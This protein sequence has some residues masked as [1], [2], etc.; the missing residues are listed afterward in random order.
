MTQAFEGAS[1]AP[2]TNTNK[3]Q[4]VYRRTQFVVPKIAVVAHAAAKNVRARGT[5]G[6]AGF[7]DVFSDLR[8]LAASVA[9]FLCLASLQT[10]SFAE[11]SQL[12]FDPSLCAED[13][14]DFVYVALWQSVFRIPADQLFYILDHPPN[15]LP[16]VPPPPKPDDPEGCPGHP[17]QAAVFDLALRLDAWPTNV[18][19]PPLVEGGAWRFKLVASGPEQWGLQP[20][21]ENRHHSACLLA[22][23]IEQDA[24]G[25][26]ICR[27]PRRDKP[28]DRSV[29]AFSAYADPDIYAAPLDRLFTSSCLASIND[30]YHNCRVAYKVLPDV[31]VSYRFRTV[32]MP[33]SQLLS[34]DRALRAR[35]KAS[36]VE[37]YDWP[38]DREIPRG[39][40][41]PPAKVD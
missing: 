1:G 13:P 37:G 29:W 34:Y 32:D 18:G 41:Q 21:L 24:S 8:R 23:E 35:L 2:G 3:V 6:P 7:R 19:D 17:I 27:V 14:G 25:L 15:E 31:N 33:I 4:L 10:P 30:R 26:L 11:S 9:A 20:S 22:A 12:T 16:R 36:R 39:S 38:I 5:R 28:N 40:P